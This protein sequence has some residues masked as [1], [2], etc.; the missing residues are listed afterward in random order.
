MLSNISSIAVN[1]HFSSELEFM[2][3]IFMYME[4]HILDLT[5]E[6]RIL[7]LSVTCMI[8]LIIGGLGRAGWY[9]R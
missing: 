2:C 7:S 6:S 3:S 4:I 9:Q 1:G 5:Y 8:K